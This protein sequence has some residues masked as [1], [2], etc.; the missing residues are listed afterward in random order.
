MPRFATIDIGTNSV[1]LLVAERRP[2]G[3]FAPVAEEAEITRLG[4]GVDQSHVLSEQGMA[5]TLLVLERYAAT[6][7]TLGA[8]GIAVTATSA[9]RDAHN[10]AAFLAEAKRRTGLT[11][12]I[13]SGDAEAR[14][15]YLAVEELYGGPGRALVVLD[16]GGGSTEL[17]YGASAS[18]T[19]G[20]S[21]T[22]PDP[23]AFRRSFDVGAVRLTERF[24]H[25]DPVPES[26]Q[27]AV[28]SHLRATFAEAPEPP[29]GFALVGVA[30]TVT[31]LFAVEHAL[32]TYDAARVE[33]QTLTLSQVR[34][35]RARLCATPLSERRTLPGLQPKR[36]D[37][38]CA[39]AMILESA[40]ARLG[41]EQVTVSD[42]GVRWGLLADRFGG[43]R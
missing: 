40:M 16:I 21:G 41:A 29:P 36:A 12:E 39:G 2:D 8:E 28:L 17:I 11:L 27:S 4:R 23:V 19:V 1:L 26:E 32:A 10:G 14:L 9:A 34:A 33:G 15:S 20:D 13:I 38:I 18:A 37:V 24:V 42:R 7:R 30:G 6:A 43:Q 3:G 25:G 31:T 22:S 35:L 5:D